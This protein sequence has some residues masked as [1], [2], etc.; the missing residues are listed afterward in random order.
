MRIRGWNIDGFG[1]FSP[2]DQIFHA[3]FKA[4][5]RLVSQGLMGQTDIGHHPIRP[6]ILLFHINPFGPVAGGL[7]DKLGQ[8]G[9]ARFN[10][11]ADI[12]H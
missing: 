5:P 2:D 11:A 12:D 1:L 3:P 8:I 4:D 7:D 6:R 9:D 10:A